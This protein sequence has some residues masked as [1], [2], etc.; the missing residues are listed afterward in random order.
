MGETFTANKEPRR[1]RA[2]QT[3]DPGESILLNPF[4]GE[5]QGCVT[6][7][8]WTL[9]CDPTLDVFELVNP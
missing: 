8:D 1:E 4:S 9:L 6:A 5:G 3:A 2:G 7:W